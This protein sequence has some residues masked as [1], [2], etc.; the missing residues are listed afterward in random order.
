MRDENG[1]KRKRER[2]VSDRRK[3]TQ[4]SPDH[5]QDAVGQ[6]GRPGRRQ[7]LARWAS[8]DNPIHCGEG[9]SRSSKVWKAA[10]AAA[11]AGGDARG[12]R[13]EENRLCKG[14]A[15]RDQCGE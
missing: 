9:C 2:T 14:K 3:R 1:D 12:E 11:A 8:E 10:A 4:R 15:D 13:A 6:L 7:I 5:L